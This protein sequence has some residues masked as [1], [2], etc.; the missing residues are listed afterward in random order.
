VT[1]RRARR[2]PRRDAGE[3]RAFRE[4]LA[5]H[6]DLRAEELGFYPAA[7]HSDGGAFLVRRTMAAH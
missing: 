6:P 5:E 3:Q 1:P 2:Q 4:L 7:G